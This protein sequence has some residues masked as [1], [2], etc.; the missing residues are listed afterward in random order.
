MLEFTKVFIRGDLLDVQHINDVRACKNIDFNHVRW[1]FNIVRDYST[2]CHI[3]D[4]ILDINAFEWKSNSFTLLH[5]IICAFKSLKQR[6][7]SIKYIMNNGYINVNTLD[8]A[9]RYAYVT[10]IRLGEYRNLVIHL[11][12]IS[13][14]KFTGFYNV[15]K[16]YDTMIVMLL[17][18]KVHKVLPKNIVRHVI[19]PFIYQ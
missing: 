8:V 18:L 13:L 14:G 16:Y 17:I 15:E 7:A 9:D 10:R 11:T 2:I 3:V 4:N 1:S 12:K 19:I 6:D 5:I